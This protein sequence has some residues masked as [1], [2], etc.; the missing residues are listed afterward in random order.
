ME[1]AGF[2]VTIDVC[3][4]DIENVKYRGSPLMVRLLTSDNIN[5]KFHI[6]I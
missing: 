1:E 2:R 6:C 4:Y 3:G 5:V